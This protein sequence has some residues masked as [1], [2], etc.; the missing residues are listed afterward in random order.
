MYELC[1]VEL[2]VSGEV[3]YDGRTVALDN[4]VRGLSAHLECFPVDTRSHLN[5][6]HRG[7]GLG[8]IRVGAVEQWHSGGVEGCRVCE[9]GLPRQNP[10]PSHLEVA[11]TATVELNE[12]CVA[13]DSCRMLR[14]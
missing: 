1:A 10:R 3:R 4:E 5:R 2:A 11:Y 14:D 6:Q 7:V 12:D 13:L 8:D 9:M